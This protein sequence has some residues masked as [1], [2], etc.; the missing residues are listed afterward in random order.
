M[1]TYNVDTSYD[2]PR[3]FLL[4]FKVKLFGI[5]NESRKSPTDTRLIVALLKMEQLPVSC[6]VMTAA[7]V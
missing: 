3:L 7:S 1:A 4:A 5:C 6:G 2:H